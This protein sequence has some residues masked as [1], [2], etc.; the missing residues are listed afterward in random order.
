MKT[1][2]NCEERNKHIICL[3]LAEVVEEFAKS[4]AL[5]SEEQEE[6]EKSIA[7]IKKA[8]NMI[9][10]RFG[11]SYKRKIV[12]TLEANT[13]RVVGK[14]GIKDQNFFTYFSQ[15]D[16]VKMAAEVVDFHCIDCPRE[17]YKDCPVYNLAITCEVEGHNEKGCPYKW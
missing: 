11:L 1:Y 5:S 14:Y 4:N 12:G 16:L 9:V 10:E 6:L 7:H 15:E 13:V 3:C 17:C 8:S 2:F